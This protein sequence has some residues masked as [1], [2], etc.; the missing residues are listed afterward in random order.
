MSWGHA[1]GVE[2]IREQGKAHGFDEQQAPES[3]W[4][5]A[6]LSRGFRLSRECLGKQPV[7]NRRG[8][9]IGSAFDL[10]QLV[11][12][13]RVKAQRGGSLALALPGLRG[14]RIGTHVLVFLD[15]QDAQDSQGTCNSS[16]SFQPVK[17]PS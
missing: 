9:G 17:L 11:P 12:Y 8:P 2:L 16:K 15:S 6:L 3:E 10:L 5:H 1:A 4:H 7:G 13:L 14:F